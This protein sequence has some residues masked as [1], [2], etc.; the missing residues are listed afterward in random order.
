V[1]T[2]ANTGAPEAALASAARLEGF[3]PAELSLHNRDNHKLRNTIERLKGMGLM[4]AIP[5]RDHER[6]LVVGVDQPDQ[7]PQ[8]NAMFVAKA[9]SRKNESSVA[10]VLNKD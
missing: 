9:A 3:D 1:S 6:P 10:R 2:L 7:I 4:A 5:S 8:D